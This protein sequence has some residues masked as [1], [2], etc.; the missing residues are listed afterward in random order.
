M[1]LAKVGGRG[2]KIAVKYSVPELHPQGEGEIEGRWSKG[3]NPPVITDAVYTIMD[4][5]NTAV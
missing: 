1:R 5:V 2:E 3:T 4:A